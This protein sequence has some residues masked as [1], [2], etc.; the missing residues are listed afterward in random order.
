MNTKGKRKNHQAKVMDIMANLQ[1]IARQQS[2]RTSWRD[3]LAF[4]HASRKEG[5]PI[6]HSF[7]LRTYQ[8][9][10]NA[11]DIDPDL[12][13]YMITL[14]FDN[15]CGERYEDDPKL[16]KIT[17]KIRDI[18]KREGLKDDEYFARGEEPDDLEKAEDEWDQRHTEIQ[19]S[20]MRD[21]GEG[22]M[23]DLYLN[24]RDE[25]DRRFCRGRKIARP[26]VNEKIDEFMNQASENRKE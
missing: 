25:Y 2:D 8:A 9:A 14:L 12:A 22:D 10:R 3:R 23:A 26:D 21:H 5:D 7:L 18:E 15:F 6:D 17:A 4:Y 13:F 24:D 11:R 16:K 19:A 1:A 20:I